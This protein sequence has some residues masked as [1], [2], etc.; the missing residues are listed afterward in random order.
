MFTKEF[1]L[2]FYVDDVAGEKAFWSA[3]GFTIFN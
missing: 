1:G 3:A 2:M